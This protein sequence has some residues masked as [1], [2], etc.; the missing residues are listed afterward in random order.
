MAGRR[1]VDVDADAVIT[2]VGELG[3][4]VAVIAGVGELAG[5]AAHIMDIMATCAALS[6]MRAGTSPVFRNEG[7]AK[8]FL[9][10]FTAA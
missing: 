3:V 1:D 10:L 6:R 7:V 2:S 8:P 9:D 4:D 5:A